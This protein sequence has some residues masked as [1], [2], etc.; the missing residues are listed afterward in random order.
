MLLE[1]THHML[2]SMK[3]FDMANSLKERLQCIDH[4]SLSAT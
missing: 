2:I 3:L 4:Q 1:H